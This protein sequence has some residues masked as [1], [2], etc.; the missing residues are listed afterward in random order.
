MRPSQS[1]FELTPRSGARTSHV[2]VLVACAFVV[3]ACDDKKTDDKPAVPASASVATTP[4]T[5]PP[6]LA[7]PPLVSL[8][9]NAVT[10][11]GDKI[12]FTGDA[13]GKLT[14]SLSGNARVAN[15]M[16]ELQALRDAKV[17]R[18]QIAIAAIKAAKAK[19]VTIKTATRE[20]STLGQIEVVFDHAPAAACSVIGMVGKDSSIMVW[21][22]G[23]GTAQ[24]FTHGMAGP[25]L[26]LGSEGMRKA[27]A[28]CDSNLY[29]VAGDDSI[30]WGLVFD[31]ALAATGDAGVMRA[32]QV[33]VLTETPVPG[34]KVTQ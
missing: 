31:L 34:R 24:R 8:D 1:W 21:P 7:R 9:D 20:L 28:T 19:G 33:V 16:I 6:P 14:A 10:V 13:K 12:D 2:V 5:T 25:D 17:P 15:E 3:N 22:V 26:T 18:V 11:Q 27:A 32:T 4:S 23:G 30:K 29:F